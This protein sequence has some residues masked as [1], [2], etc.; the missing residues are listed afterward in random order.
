MASWPPALDMLKADMND[1]GNAEDETRDDVAL[2]LVLDAAV[3]FVQAV[4]PQYAYAGDQLTDLPEPPAYLGLGTVRLATRWHERRRSPAALV[5][6]G[7]MG[8]SRIP[9]FDPDIEQLL[10]IGRYAP[11]VIA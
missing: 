2:Q 3:S 5:A 9:S 1:Q 10:R 11:P 4:K 8:A 6:M 7:E